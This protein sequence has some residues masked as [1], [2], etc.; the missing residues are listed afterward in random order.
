MRYEQPGPNRLCSGTL[1][2]VT[3]RVHIGPQDS[4][5]EETRWHVSAVK[6]SDCPHVGCG[7]SR[8]GRRKRRC[9]VAVREE[10]VDQPRCRWNMVLS[11]V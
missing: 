10:G 1:L 7:L 8:R 9:H 6:A 3:L 4:V 2:M 5:D 11:P